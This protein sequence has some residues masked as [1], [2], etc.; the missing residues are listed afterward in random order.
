V[1]RLKDNNCKFSDIV[2]A[3]NKE[4]NQSYKLKLKNLGTQFAYISDIYDDNTHAF[5]LYNRV[6]AHK[7][8]L[9]Q[10]NKPEII[11]LI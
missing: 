1:Q 5:D 8:L 6:E 2:S 7:I 4:T 10:M 9:D 3:Y 11:D